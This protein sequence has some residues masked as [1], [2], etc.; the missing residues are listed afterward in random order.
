[1]RGK[2]NRNSRAP[3]N[4]HFET[5]STEIAV[6]SAPTPSGTF[7]G[8]ALPLIPTF[9]PASRLGQLGVLYG[10]YQ[11]V[12]SR[13]RYVPNASTAWTGRIVTAWS[14]D[15]S[16]PL[17]TSA[18]LLSQIAGARECSVHQH[19]STRTSR[20]QFEKRRYPTIDGLS[21][22][23]LTKPDQ[24]IYLPAT[25]WYSIDQCSQSGSIMGNLYWD[26]KIRFFNPFLTNPTTEVTIITLARD[27][28]N[29]WD[30]FDNNWGTQEPP[31]PASIEAPL[32]PTQTPVG[33]VATASSVGK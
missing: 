10:Q 20:G 11:I 6:I 8:A 4:S 31:S 7:G 25:L 28:E 19:L 24:Q 30:D 1:M 15:A 2:S 18:H 22:V 27:A 16:N 33:T 5:G 32:P 3:R 13:V 14:Y 26:Y 12:S 23:A 21:F 17:P 9:E 29:N